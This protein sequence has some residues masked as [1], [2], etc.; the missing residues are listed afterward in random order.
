MSRS[1]SYGVNKTNVDEIIK[2]LNLCDEN[3]T[4]P[5][6]S[7]INIRDYAI[8]ITNNAVRFEATIGENLIGLLAVYI[9]N[10]RK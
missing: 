2:H 10:Q 3:F 1:I 9:N 6:S 7:R 8:K 4:P 5:L